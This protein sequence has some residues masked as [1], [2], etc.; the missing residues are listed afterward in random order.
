MEPTFT[1]YLVN[2]QVNGHAMRVWGGGFAAAMAR[3]AL[4]ANASSRNLAHGRGQEGAF[5]RRASADDMRAN[6]ATDGSVIG[7]DPSVS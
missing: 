6:T 3:S 1:V 7:P 2:Q 5:V 4:C